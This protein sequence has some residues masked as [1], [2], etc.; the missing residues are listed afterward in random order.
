M[1]RLLHDVTLTASIGKLECHLTDSLDG[2]QARK[3]L[4][5]KGCQAV[6]IGGQVHRIRFTVIDDGK[7]ERCIRNRFTC[8]VE[9]SRY[10]EAFGSCKKDGV[11]QFALRKVGVGDVQRGR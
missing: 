10:V 9:M 2:A 1:Q 11:V 4:N 7:R 5:G 8:L 6:F 3:G